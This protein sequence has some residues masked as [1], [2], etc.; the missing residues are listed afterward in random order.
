MDKPL[1]TVVPLTSL[2][3][4]IRQPELW[5]SW[6]VTWFPSYND[7]QNWHIKMT[8]IQQTECHRQSQHS[9]K[10]TLATKSP[11]TWPPSPLLASNFVFFGSQNTGPNIAFM[12]QS[13]RENWDLFLAFPR[14]QTNQSLMVTCLPW[15]WW[16]NPIFFTKN[17]WSWWK[18]WKEFGYNSLF[19]HLWYHGQ[20]L[21]LSRCWNGSSPFIKNYGHHYGQFFGNKTRFGAA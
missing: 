16:G 15:S 8:G 12:S 9:T 14:F 19:F 21:K 11:T 2:T 1:T 10:N 7:Q 4:L 18:C 17:F 13:P 20:M 6:G 5:T 3:S